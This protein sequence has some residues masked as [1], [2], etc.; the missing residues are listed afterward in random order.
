MAENAEPATR[1][2]GKPELRRTVTWRTGVLVALGTAVLICVSLGPMAESIGT[3]SVFVWL[4]T[5]LIG[6]LQCVLLADLAQRFP[7]RAGGTATYAYAV[8]GLERPVLGALS[9]WG[10]WCAWTPGIAINLILAAEYLRATVLPSVP[11]LVIMAVISVTLYLVNALGLDVWA[12]CSAVVAVVA[13][14]PL[15]I[16]MIGL[17]LNPGML[18]VDR[19][20]RQDLPG[21]DFSNGAGWALIAKWAFV[22]AWSAYGAEMAS[23]IVA[24]MRDPQLHVTRMMYLAGV[25]CSVIFG[26]VP[27]LLVMAVG[28]TGLA[29]DPATVFLPAAEAVFGPAGAVV[30]GL[31][32]AAGLVLGAQAFIVG[33][34]RTVF[35]M[36][37]D[38]Y[39]PRQ[40]SWINRRG[41]PIGSLLLDVPII[42]GLVL[43]FGTD[44]VGVVASAN[45]GYLVVFILMP[46]AYL[47][48][49][50]R[51]RAER[52]SVNG[53]RARDQLAV[54]LALLN[55]ILLI[56]G[57][58]QWG[59]KVVGI[60][61]LV[62]A[63]AVPMAMMHRRRAST[64]PS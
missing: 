6:A 56:V 62:L 1:Q 51:D 48:L 28:G 3:V 63:L 14:P 44:V 45:F 54:G 24:E 25:I 16:L 15:I 32:L 5:G 9:S 42:V 52:R 8:L 47:V 43:A 35:Q 59:P 29:Q 4:G 26:A 46:V 11:V 31:M 55:I 53:S 39:L 36:T 41:A 37:V 20:F 2:S 17:I 30:V 7:S 49:R 33:S 58:W 13:L 23:T 18:D 12:Y 38:G 27:L 61:F 34:S 19:L 21:V 64:A 57:G 22:A 10:Y 40:L 50:H 60:G